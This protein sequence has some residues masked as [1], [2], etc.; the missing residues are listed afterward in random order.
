[1]GGLGGRLIKKNDV[2]KPKLTDY[3]SIT[4][5]LG[6]LGIVTPLWGFLFGIAGILLSGKTIKATKDINGKNHKIAVGGLV[7]SIIAIIIQIGAVIYSW[8]LDLF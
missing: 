5:G 8:A 2:S 3:A 6:F 1:M 4:V 7:C